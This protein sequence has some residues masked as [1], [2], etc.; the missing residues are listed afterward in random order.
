MKKTG[1]KRIKLCEWEKK[2]YNLMDADSNPTLN[3][4]P[5]M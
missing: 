3:K 5:G 1:N 4:I 2:L